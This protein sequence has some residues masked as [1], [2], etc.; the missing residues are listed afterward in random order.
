MVTISASV[1]F[2][3]SKLAQ[4]SARSLALKWKAWL[5]TSI[6][7]SVHSP[8]PPLDDSW[9]Y[10]LSDVLRMA[11]GVGP[12]WGSKLWANRDGVRQR[13][14]WRPSPTTY[15]EKH[16]LDESQD[17]GSRTT[18]KVH[19]VSLSG[20]WDDLQAND[21]QGLWVGLASWFTLIIPLPWF[22]DCHW[23]THQTHQSFQRFVARV[24]LS[25]SLGHSSSHA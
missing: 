16:P 23:A 9:W 2:R 5:L 19:K 7:R 11:R 17:A 18:N 20:H 25:L 12:G 13:C 24:S 14:F 3:F 6:G 8:V 10:L 15:M 1:P 22:H 21:K 4:L